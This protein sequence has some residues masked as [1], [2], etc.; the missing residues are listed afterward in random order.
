M[1]KV[2]E[3]L[4]N[5]DEFILF[6]EDRSARISSRIIFVNHKPLIFTQNKKHPIVDD[7]T[8][9][10]QKK[11]DTNMY[12]TIYDTLHDA[13][14]S[15]YNAIQTSI[16]SK[17]KFADYVDICNT[18]LQQMQTNETRL[19]DEQKS[20]VALLQKELSTHTNPHAVMT[21]LYTLSKLLRYNHRI[22]QENLLDAA[23]RKTQTRKEEL[24]AIINTLVPQ[25]HSLQK[26]LTDNQRHIDQLHSY[27]TL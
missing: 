17:E 20:E 1:Q 19:S 12:F 26:I 10:E 7:P 24:K 6:P 3:V 5:Y 23:V 8:K 14:S 25:L 27:I 15:Q 22:I 9:A 16:R 4:A 2:K 18:L 21:T 11:I 13:I